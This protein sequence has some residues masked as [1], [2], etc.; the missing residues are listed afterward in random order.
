MPG[1]LKEAAMRGP[2]PEH[3][4]NRGISINPD[5]CSAGE[6]KQQSEGQGPNCSEYGRLQYGLTMYISTNFVIFKMRS[7][8]RAKTR[9]FLYEGLFY[10]YCILQDS[11]SSSQ[12]RAKDQAPARAKRLSMLLSQI[13]VYERVSS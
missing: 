8:A 13:E 3:V 6:R 4:F 5:T 9:A 7:R 10:K 11:R 1:N 2:S 12:A